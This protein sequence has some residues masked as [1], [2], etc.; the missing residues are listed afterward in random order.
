MMTNTKARRFSS[1]QLGCAI[2]GLLWMIVFLYAWLALGM[3]I[4]NLFDLSVIGVSLAFGAVVGVLG[5]VTAFAAITA[6]RQEKD[7]THRDD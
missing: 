4:A 6:Y 5:L 3:S 2:G 7:S 1:A